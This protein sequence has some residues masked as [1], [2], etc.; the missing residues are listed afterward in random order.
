[1][2]SYQGKVGE[3]GRKAARPGSLKILGQVELDLKTSTASEKHRDLQRRLAR[4]LVSSGKVKSVRAEYDPAGLHAYD[5]YL[6]W[7]DGTTEA[8][9]VMRRAAFGDI[10]YGRRRRESLLDYALRVK[11]H[12]DDPDSSKLFS[13]G[14]CGA[15][16]NSVCVPIET[17]GHVMS[18]VEKSGLRLSKIYTFGEEGQDPGFMAVQ[19]R[20]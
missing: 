2:A 5:L 14:T 15:D 10:P 3:S 20:Q 16:M 9:E 17:Y 18:R 8:I 11:G 4:W 7:S 6:E 12:G 13:Y 1:M 19:V